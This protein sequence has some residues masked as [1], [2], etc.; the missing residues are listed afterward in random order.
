MKRVLLQ[1]MHVTKKVVFD[2]EAPEMEEGEEE[3]S[4]VLNL[5]CCSDSFLGLDQQYDLEIAL[6][7]AEEE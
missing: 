1:P 4:F 3:E 2:F 7:P 5:M 6:L